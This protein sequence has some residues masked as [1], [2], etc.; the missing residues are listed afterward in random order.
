MARTNP[1][2][3]YIAKRETLLEKTFR[4]HETALRR[5]FRCRLALEAD[6]EDLVQELFLKLSKMEHLAD[7]LAEYGGNTR[8]YLLAIAHNLV[9]DLKR[10]AAV[11]K[12]DRHES[13][14]EDTVP[15]ATPAP[16]ELATTTQQM[17]RVMARLKGMDP[18]YQQVL[19][20]NKF[21]Q[22]SCREI[23]EEMDISEA[24]VERYLAYALQTVRK[25][26]NNE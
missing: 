22:K 18:K 6:R 12:F 5:F 13:Y 25:G 10:H 23:S 26:L 9:V 8:A 15:T 7:K 2:V 24:T 21:M 17:D 19:L 1:K 11:R 16:P 3:V 4:D 14:H 20:L